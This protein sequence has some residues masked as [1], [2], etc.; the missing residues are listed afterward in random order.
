MSVDGAA[1]VSLLLN[2][3]RV[4]SR[5]TA[6]FEGCYCYFENWNSI[7]VVMQYLRCDMLC[8][9]C[10]NLYMVVHGDK[11]SLLTHDHHA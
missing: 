1:S 6:L 5:H 3:M 10:R 2:T 8:E 11:G 4:S 7:V 9:F